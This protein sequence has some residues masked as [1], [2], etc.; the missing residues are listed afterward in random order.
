MLKQSLLRVVVLALLPAVAVVLVVD[1][2]WPDVAR[3]LAVLDQAGQPHPIPPL[4]ARTF[5]GIAI[6]LVLL[7]FVGYFLSPQ[8][9]LKVGRTPMPD[10]LRGLIR[11]GLFLLAFAVILKAVWGEEV[12][13]LLGALGIGGIV[14]GL[15][16]QET[17]SNLFAGLSLLAEKPFAPGD[18]IRIGDRQEGQVEHITW[19]A[20]KIRTRDNDYEIFPNSLVGK[21]V[22]VNFRQPEVVH[23]IRLAIGTSYGDAPDKVKR[24][25]QDV[26]AA[27][28]GVLRQPQPTVY[29][30]GY[31]DFSINYEIKCFIEDYVNRPA[32]EDRIMHRI[33]YAFRRAGVEIPFPIQ[34]S[35]EYKMTFDAAAA[36]KRVNLDAVI[37]AV[38][39]FAHLGEE[40]RGRLAAQA[41]LLDFGTGEAVIRQ[42]EP[43]D[44]LYIVVSGAVNV[45]LRGEDGAERTVAMFGQGDFFGEMALLTGE[46]RVATAYAEGALVVCRVAKSALEP[47]LRANPEA[48]EKMAEVA[49]MRKQGLDKVRA[50]LT[51]SSPRMAEMHREARSILGKIRALFR[52]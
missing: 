12:A 7:S 19:R 45:A 1:A 26:L 31:G 44:S 20:T 28:P 4:L 25:I 18:W 16:L 37:G 32:I 41:S 47:V 8:R 13:P 35:Y 33:W 36:G 2:Y 24:V 29:L 3:R 11:Y 23:A 22:I 27:V 43:G 17:L 21:E 5:L 9:A 30:K 34:T 40:E 51:T 15:A 52:L 46:P 10:L 50:E 38:P 14:I 42:G 6:A 39:V 48:A 49:A